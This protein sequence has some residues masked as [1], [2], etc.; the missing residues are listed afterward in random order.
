MNTTE[1]VTVFNKTCL[2]SKW[3]GCLLWQLIAALEKKTSLKAQLLKA[4]A[5]MSQT[6]ED[7]LYGSQKGH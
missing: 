1:T 5:L 6:L 7:N 3:F 2:F 4:F